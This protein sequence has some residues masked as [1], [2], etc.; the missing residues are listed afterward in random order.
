[1]IEHEA[2]AKEWMSKNGLTEYNEYTQEA[3]HTELLDSLIAYGRAVERE[4]ETRI[5]SEY[6]SAKSDT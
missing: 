2:R 4:V 3:L 1:M 6:A 5:R